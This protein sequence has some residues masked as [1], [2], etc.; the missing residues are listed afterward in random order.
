MGLPTADAVQVFCRV[1]FCS[2]CLCFT[3]ISMGKTDQFALPPP[4]PLKTII[5]FVWPQYDGGNID[6]EQLAE[7]PS[8]T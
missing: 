2:C 3:T 7:V 6:K 4:L 8:I 1:F 5:V